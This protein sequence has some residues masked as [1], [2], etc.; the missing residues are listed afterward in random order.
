LGSLLFAL[1]SPKSAV[2][3]PGEIDKEKSVDL[4]FLSR[5]SLRP[6]GI[7]RKN[8]EKSLEI[9]IHTRLCIYILLVA[10]DPRLRCADH[11]A[12]VAGIVALDAKRMEREPADVMKAN[13]A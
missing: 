12:S 4:R 8:A 13:H 1:A 2:A 11:F 3:R 7:W 9:Q 5:E 10:R 6:K